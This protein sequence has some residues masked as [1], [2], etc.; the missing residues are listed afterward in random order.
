MFLFLALQAF[1]LIGCAQEP[2]TK[3]KAQELIEASA[4]FQPQSV[5]VHLTGEEVKKGTDAGYWSLVEMN[6]TNSSLPRMQIMSLTPMGATFFRGA[7]PMFMPVMQINQKLGGR[8]IEITKMEDDA[9]SAKQKTVEFTW[10]RRFENQVP[11]LVELFKD[12]PA[13]QAK[14]KFLYGKSGWELVP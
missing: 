5:S 1:L 8:V 4:E 11:E 3:E 12:Q 14:K 13:Q 7:P 2:L 6:R 9:S 10:T